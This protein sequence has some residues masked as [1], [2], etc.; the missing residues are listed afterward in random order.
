MVQLYC[1]IMKLIFFDE[2]YYQSFVKAATK[3]R[4]QCHVVSQ[5]YTM[6]GRQ[7]YITQFLQ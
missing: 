4:Y 5:Y 3:Y 1:D 7:L 6:L 2:H